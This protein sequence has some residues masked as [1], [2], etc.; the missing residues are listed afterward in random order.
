[1]HHDRPQ[2]AK[3]AAIGELQGCKNSAG[4][5][6]L[7]LLQGWGVDRDI[8]RA[9]QLARTSAAAGSRYGQ[10]A[11]A[12]LLH[13]KAEAVALYASHSS[14]VLLLPAVYYCNMLRRYQL[15]A[16]QGLDAAPYALGE[17]FHVGDGVSADNE[18]AMRL[19]R[20]AAVQGFP[21]AF[22]TL[23]DLAGGDENMR[24]HWLLQSYLAGGDCGQRSM[25]ALGGYIKAGELLDR[26][27]RM[28]TRELLER[29]TPLLSGI[30]QAEQD[31]EEGVDGGLRKVRKT[32][33]E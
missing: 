27:T 19:Y 13:D 32:D 6:S 20:L 11:L 7:C 4:V 30:T 21:E 17:R 29:Q 10:F 33:E 24:L 8:E 25:S 18:E 22:A 14:R 2:A 12:S 9:R 16:A 3:L 28:K 26:T 23:A 1:M 31:D 15:A 5:L